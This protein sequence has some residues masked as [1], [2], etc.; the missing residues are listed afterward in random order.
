MVCYNCVS[1]P[2]GY[3]RI[4]LLSLNGFTKVIATP[5]YETIS[6]YVHQLI[7]L[8]ASRRRQN[9]LC[10]GVHLFTEWTGTE[11]TKFTPYFIEWSGPTKKGLL[12]KV[13]LVTLVFCLCFCYNA[14]SS[15]W[16]ATNSMQ[17]C[18]SIRSMQ[19]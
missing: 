18:L 10:N 6:Y 14:E 5:K 12:Q 11:W 19:N 7:Y 1:N 9:E 4:S 15:H 13:S 2:L 17:G 16:S 3:L 8:N